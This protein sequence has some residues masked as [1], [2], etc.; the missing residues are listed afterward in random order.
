MLGSIPS[1]DFV[2]SACYMPMARQS[3]GTCLEHIGFAEPLSPSVVYDIQPERA[4]LSR[5]DVVLELA[6]IAR[7]AI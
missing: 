7:D 6:L 3:A 2:H 4:R 5:L 1:C